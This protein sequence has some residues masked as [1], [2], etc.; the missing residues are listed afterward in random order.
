MN[1]LSWILAIFG[2]IASIVGCLLA[3]ITFINPM[4][5]LKRYL[6]KTENWEKI[7]KNRIKYNWHYKKHPEFYIEQSDDEEDRDN[8]TAVESWMGYFPDPSKKL[9]LMKVIFNGLVLITEDFIS[10]DGGRYF[11]PLP[12]RELVSRSDSEFKY[13]YDSIQYKLGK[14]LGDFYRFNDNNSLD[15]FMESHGIE[16]R[17]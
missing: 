16:Y 9:Y 5:R 13:Y 7:Y 15:K 12:R 1:I 11:V 2:L 14:I 3:Y 6:S 8:F 10:L 17:G 4:F